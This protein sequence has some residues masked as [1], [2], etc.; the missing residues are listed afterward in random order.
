MD[1]ARPRGGLRNVFG[2]IAGALFVVGPAL[3]GLRL[4][5]GIVGF[6]LFALGGIGGLVVGA[7]SVVQAAR[8]RG[9]GRGGAVAVGVGVVFLALALRS[10]GAPRINDFTT[11]PANPPAF[12]HAATL[13]RNA[14]R[15]MSYPKA[16][17]AI[18]HD[19]CADLRPARVRTGA[20]EALA[21]AEAV[22]RQMGLTVT[23]R[24][25]SAGL[26]EAMAT[27]RLF[28][29]HDD[30]AIRVRPE[31]DGTSRV[32]VRSKSRDGQG[33][34]GVNAARIRTFVGAIEAAA[35]TPP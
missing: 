9:L 34:L 13:P 12:T 30:V 24:D 22:V 25:P 15:D 21:R 1:D 20:P 11:D 32:D 5:P 17:A 19:C 26:L 6:G 23:W 18:Q 3:A 27:S 33:D 14:G 2:V 16:F 7:V 4:V 31:A 35:A 29:F 28:G 8:A 10:A